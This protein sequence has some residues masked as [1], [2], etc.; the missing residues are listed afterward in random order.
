[1]A[2]KDLT[3]LLKA[4]PVELR[5]TRDQQGQITDV[6]YIPNRRKDPDGRT[7]VEF[8]E[9]LSLLGLTHQEEMK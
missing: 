6:S 3:S 5:I 1:M 8:L 2:E 4:A 9:I 7:H